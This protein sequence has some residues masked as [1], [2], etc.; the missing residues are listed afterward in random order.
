M[1]IGSNCQVVVDVAD[2]VDDAAVAAD[3]VTADDAVVAADLVVDDEDDAVVVFVVADV[4]VAV[5]DVAV[6]I[7]A[8]VVD[9]SWSKYCFFKIRWVLYNNINYSFSIF[10]IIFS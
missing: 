8:F 3:V 4:D 10:N 7:D 2:V 5:V 9:D 1:Q 6:V